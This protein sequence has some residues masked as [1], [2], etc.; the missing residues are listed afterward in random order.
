MNPS[1]LKSL[2]GRLALCLALMVGLAIAPTATLNADPSEEAVAKAKADYDELMATYNTVRQG[3][4]D[5][6]AL[7]Q[8]RTDALAY[9]DTYG[10]DD[11][12]ADD[13]QIAMCLSFATWTHYAVA[14]YAASVEFAMNQLFHPLER[15][16][17]MRAP[18]D[19][20]DV[21]AGRMWYWIALNAVQLD[22]EELA[23]D[24]V[25][26]AIALDSSYGNRALSQVNGKWPAAVEGKAAPDFTLPTITDEGD[27]TLSELKGKVVIVDFWATW[28]GPCKSVM[29][30]YLQPWQERFGGNE[31]FQL[32]SVGT[33]WRA[34]TPEK[35]LAY[36]KE[37]DYHWT[38]VFDADGST[39]AMYGV[40]G[41]PT[42]VIVNP[43]GVI[44][45][46]SSGLGADKAAEV[47]AYLVEQLGGEGANPNGNTPSTG[48]TTT[49]PNNGSGTGTA[50]GTLGGSTTNAAGASNED[51]AAAKEA[52]DEIYEMHLT[53]RRS[54][55]DPA[56]FEQA[57][58]D[59]LVPSLQFV[60]K[61]NKPNSGATPAQIGDA[62]QYACWSLYDREMVSLAL[63]IAKGI[64]FDQQG[65][66]VEQSDIV[67]GKMWFWVA[68]TQIQLGHKDEALHAVERTMKINPEQAPIARS[69]YSQRFGSM[70]GSGNSNNGAGS[71]ADNGSA[72][73]PV[74]GLP[75]VG[76]EAPDFTLPTINGEG[77]V[78]LS[79]LRDKFVVVDFW[80]TWCGP[81][82]RVMANTLAPLFEKYGERDDFAMVSVGLNARDTAEKQLAYADEQGYHW[83]KLFDT[84]NTVQKLYNIKAIPTLLLIDTDGKILAVGTSGVASTIESM[85]NER[86]ADTPSAND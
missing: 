44:Q 3:A 49:G 86:F 43:E 83:T 60:D 47:E 42:I 17:D 23:R 55:R 30:K 77:D 28:C 34:D 75:A 79:D 65:N 33:N 66:E 25:N 6:D 40:R 84:D 2:A 57:L 68:K 26:K 81:C 52:F 20:P 19:L 31:N 46:M 70:P 22:D 32:I 62:L 24:A 21:I 1:D 11:G 10:V 35:Q 53:A 54:G 41:I 59:M 85:L 76:T 69:L 45:F 63:A 27:V 39:T 9:I 71:S 78:T 36:A 7:A 12:G 56:A 48:S 61:F 82:K 14:D 18:R 4:P 51:I 5:A 73:A 58:A 8:F 64:L 13:S 74:S 50:G 67:A 72:T 38:K 29:A 16:S 15:S 80:A 37:M